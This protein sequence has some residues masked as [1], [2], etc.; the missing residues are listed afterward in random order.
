MRQIESKH[1]LDFCGYIIT[2]NVASPTLTSFIIISAELFRFIDRFRWLNNFFAQKTQLNR[3]VRYI[4][5]KS[6]GK[7][8]HY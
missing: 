1:S 8:K 2:G 4:N 3:F 5:S 6:T 7:T